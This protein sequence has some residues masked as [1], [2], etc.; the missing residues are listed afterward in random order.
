M[1]IENSFRAI[2][3]IRKQLL[4]SYTAWTKTKRNLKSKQTSN[5][6]LR[7]RNLLSHLDYNDRKKWNSVSLAKRSSFNIWH[8]PSTVYL[9]SQFNHTQPL[10]CLGWRNFAFHSS[11]DMVIFFSSEYVCD[12]KR[13]TQIVILRCTCSF[14]VDILKKM[15]GL[16]LIAFWFGTRLFTDCDKNLFILD[17]IQSC[18]VKIF[19][20]VNP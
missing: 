16:F 7:K 17:K 4:L 20:E 3:R 6:Y 12:L 11:F 8:S 13:R 9:E 5:G 18:G 19:F 10:S 2:S 15:L 14:Y 1:K